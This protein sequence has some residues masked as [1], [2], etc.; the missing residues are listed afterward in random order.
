MLP[1]YSGL[2]RKRAQSQPWQVLVGQ[3]L[4]SAIMRQAASLMSLS[5][6][7]GV[8]TQDQLDT[9]AGLGC[10]RAQGF[11]LARPMSAEAVVELVAKTLV[12]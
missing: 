12:P 8:E 3:S 10:D 1:G 11:L 6:A 5:S 9:L 4:T 2:G 7:R